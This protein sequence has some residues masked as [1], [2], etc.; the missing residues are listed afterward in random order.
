MNAFLVGSLLYLFIYF[1]IFFLRSD[2]RKEMLVAGLVGAVLGLTEPLFV[3]QYWTPQ[4]IYNFKIDTLVFDIESIIFGFAVGGTASV[5]LDFIKG[6]KGYDLPKDSLNEKGILVLSAIFLLAILAKFFL[7]LNMIYVAIGGFLLSSL[8]IATR[9]K[10]L[11]GN[12]ILGALIFC[13]LYFLIYILLNRF[14]FPGWALREWNV[15]KISGIFLFGVPIEEIAWALATG[16]LWSPA[17]E[18]LR[19]IKGY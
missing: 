6:S 4:T 5:F 3:P 13:G 12:S 10:D 1:I 19:N 9:R 14:L 2:L 18:Y 8:V 15:E 17:Y 16:M 7:S 11:L